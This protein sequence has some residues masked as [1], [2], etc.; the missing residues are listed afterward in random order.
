MSA[1][2]PGNLVF[3]RSRQSALRRRSNIEASI[4]TA[5][6]RRHRW[7][8]AAM[9]FSTF[10]PFDSPSGLCS[11][12]PHD[13]GHIES[14]SEASCRTGKR[15]VRFRRGDVHF[16]FGQKTRNAGAKAATTQHTFVGGGRRRWKKDCACVLSLLCEPARN[17]CD[18]TSGEQRCVQWQRARLNSKTDGGKKNR[19]KNVF[20]KK[21]SETKQ[22]FSL[23][24]TATSSP[25]PTLLRPLSLL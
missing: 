14:P 7:S 13:S 19:R 22:C 1:I 6:L 12:S 20:P 15:S 24:S 16:Q 4:E 18:Q 9:L 3:A 2:F 21:R 23:D 11:R 25:L 17:S 5:A 8:S 10:L